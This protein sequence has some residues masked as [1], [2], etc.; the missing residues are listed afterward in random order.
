ML[1][2]PSDDVA[3]PG[4]VWPVRLDPTGVSGPTRGQARSI[5]WRRSSH[6]YHVP[7]D[8]D[9]DDL[10]QRIAEAGAPMA[11]THAVTGWAALHWLG[12]RWFSGRRADGSAVP[13]DVLVS[14]RDPNPRTGVELSGEGTG[15]DNLLVVD[16]LRVTSGVWSTSFAMRHAPTLLEA[17]TVL[18]MA[19]YSDLV[20]VEEQRA[21]LDGQNSW[22]GIP[23]AR[24]AADQA[25]ENAWSPQ[26][27]AMRII[28]TTVAGLPDP[29]CNAPVF[30]LA[31]RHLGT[32]DLIDP[33]TGVMGEY[34]GDAHLARARRHHDVVRAESLRDHGLEAVVFMAPDVHDPAD[35]VRRLHAAR[36]RS[37]QRA[38]QAR[39]WTLTKP[40]WWVAT[41]AVDQ[42]RALTPDQRRR[43]LAYR[44]A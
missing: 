30:D 36:R 26:E 1:E 17:V 20:S 42:R 7:S 3:H 22:T 18:D 8:V 43:L 28:W 29:R 25:V 35:A 39:R 40:A 32:P 44:A 33:E 41:E 34:D 12:G 16:G 13:V 23:L 37:A 4:V 6:G 10:N 31:G 14:T 2:P 15:P 27:V 11:D 24:R 19:A 38:P 9:S 5:R 21:F